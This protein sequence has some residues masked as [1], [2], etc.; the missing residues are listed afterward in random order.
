M[1][2]ADVLIIGGGLSGL[3]CAHD[4]QQ[5]GLRAHIL[6][7][8]ETVGGRVRSDHIE[9][10]VCD[11]GF[12]VFLPAYPTAS[13]VF[14]PLGIDWKAY[15]KSAVIHDGDN[16]QWFGAPFTSGIGEKLRLTPRDYWHFFRDVSAGLQNS[17][18]T[19]T[20]PTHT[21]LN[22]YSKTVSDQFLKPFFSSVFLDP[23]LHAPASLFQYY[24]SL[25]VRGGVAVPSHGMG[26][27]TQRLAAQLNPD[28]L[29]THMPVTRISKAGG[30]WKVE[31]ETGSFLAPII[32]M[33]TAHHHACALLQELPRPTRA[34]PVSTHYFLTD[35]IPDTLGP[36]TLF[37]NGTNCHHVA[38]P[39]RVAPNYTP[40]H[41][42]L[43]MATT[44]GTDT[45]SAEAVLD[46]LARYTQTQHWRWIHHVKLAHSLPDSHAIK[47]P[48]PTCILA[49]DWT[50]LPSIEGA[51]RSGKLAAQAIGVT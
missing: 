26:E 15:P 42:H 17:K 9:G 33:A 14:K 47:H 45:V 39:T 18:C 4:C 12:Q 8:N 49:G 34:L 16:Q 23:E 2:Q 43:I 31:T 37:P 27:I 44:Y 6:E 22:R 7:A 10:V 11:R 40:D 1:T 46:E 38:I 48:D 19:G 35:T 32:V 50:A 20:V 13:A 30:I 41:R 3:V 25:F 5:N 21:H 36:L 28:T 51:C 24:L 29:Q